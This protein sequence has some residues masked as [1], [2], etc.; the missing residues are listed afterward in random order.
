MRTLKRSHTSQQCSIKASFFLQNW[1]YPVITSKYEIGKKPVCNFTN[2]NKMGTWGGFEEG[3]EDQR[4][5]CVFV[6]WLN[7]VTAQR[8]SY[9]IIPSPGLCFV[10]YTAKKFF[11]LNF[12][13]AFAQDYWF[14]QKATHGKIILCVVVEITVVGIY[15]TSPFLFTSWN[16][17][18][19]AERW[20]G[21]FIFTSILI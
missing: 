3:N 5:I 20:T 6:C 17:T 12:K 21:H 18:V 1:C 10:S 13:T 15:F 8:F 14:G 16:S 4:K 19:R 9:G 2:R 7:S 11:F